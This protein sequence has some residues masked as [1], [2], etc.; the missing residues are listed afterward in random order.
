MVLRRAPAAAG[1]IIRNSSGEVIKATAFSLGSAPSF[2]SEAVALHL[3]IQAAIR[4]GIMNLI[5]E[6]DNLL[7]INAVQKLWKSPWKIDHIIKDVQA[8]LHH[9]SEI[10]FRHIYREGNRAADWIANMEL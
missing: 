9:F 2:V 5:V 1:I 6:G 4:L 3:G 10:T 7:V 8:L